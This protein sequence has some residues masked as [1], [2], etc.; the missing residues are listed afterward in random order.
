M[1]VPIAA[2]GDYTAIDEDLVLGPDVASSCVNISTVDNDVF[3]GDKTITVNLDTM[4]ERVTLNF[5]SAQVTI[6]E[7][8]GEGGHLVG[9]WL[10]RYLV[11]PPTEVVIGFMQTGVEVG[12]G[13]TTSLTVTIMNGTLGMD[14][15]LEVTITSMDT[16]TG[17][18]M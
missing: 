16:G 11:S 13:Q 18:Y 17:L 7:D 12:E 1:C 5:S 15:Q 3:E 8:D 2:P 9:M 4:E 14:T 6:I 10:P